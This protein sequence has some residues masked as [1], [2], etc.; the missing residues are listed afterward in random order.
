MPAPGSQYSYMLEYWEVVS[1]IVPDN[2]LRRI[3]VFSGM[4]EPVRLPF[5]PEEPRYILSQVSRQWRD[6]VQSTTSFWDHIYLTPV[7]PQHSSTLLGHFF[8]CLLR[9]GNNA[10]SLNFHMITGGWSFSIVN[11][12]IKPNAERIKSLTCLLYGQDIETFLNI[13]EG[14]F[15]VLE[16]QWLNFTVFCSLPHIRQVTLHILNGLHPFDLRLPW[17]QL[18]ALDMGTTAMPP[19][20][21]IKIIGEARSSLR[22]AFFQIRFH[23]PACP[24]LRL[25][26]R[27][28]TLKKLETLRF[29]LIYPTQD[30]RLFAL[31]R[32]PNLR[33]LYIEMHDVFQDWDME[34]YTGILRRSTKSLR[35]LQLSD[36]S[37]QG[38]N[39]PPPN[40]RHRD[41]SYHELERFFTVVR[42]INFLH[43]PLSVHIHASTMEKLA[44]GELLPR[45]TT[46]E[47]GSINGKD[48][49]SM[50]K[51]RNEAVLSH[52]LAPGP[53]SSTCT[54]LSFLYLVIPRSSCRPEEKRDFD[55]EV[56]VL[57]S[58]GVV[59]RI[60][61][62]DGLP[63]E[64]GRE[65]EAK[66]VHI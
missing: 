10:L 4:N 66:V 8:R 54:Y 56:E 40:R 63:L 37:Q 44:T 61:P 50:V 48:V 9:S 2:V 64:M 39:M 29:R 51:R 7:L 55:K 20:V 45:L 28:I 13:Q 17:R 21:F 11:W 34:M 35:Y 49:L 31:L 62:T 43:L 14:R 59:C 42:N 23:K 19:D 33:D 16:A 53:S 3:L 18:T 25:A 27:E 52:S 6:G 12:I 41:T 15:R 22:D 30:P 5:R 60:E 47:L 36:F 1:Y 26:P 38:S 46:L 58:L 57:R 65:R 32:F 24:G